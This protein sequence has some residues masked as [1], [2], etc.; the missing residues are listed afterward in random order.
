MEEAVRRVTLAEAKKLARAAYREGYMCALSEVAASI[1]DIREGGRSDD[2]WSDSSALKYINM[3]EPN[4]GE[5]P[6]T[7]DS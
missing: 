7:S 4:D 5:T 2:G 6:P 1:E 3:K